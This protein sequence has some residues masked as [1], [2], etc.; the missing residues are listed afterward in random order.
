MRGWVGEQ[1]GFVCIPH[2]LILFHSDRRER[3]GGVSDVDHV[4]AYMHM[5]IIYTCIHSICM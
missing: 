4:Y 3:V 1:E 2:P 5:H